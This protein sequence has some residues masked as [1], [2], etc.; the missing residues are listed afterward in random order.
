M[1]IGT[2]SPGEKLTVNGS[3]ML[4]GPSN[5]TDTQ[6]ESKIIFT[7]DLTDTDESE[8]NAMIYTDY[9]G[10]LTLDSGRGVVTALR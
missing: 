2:D 1:G 8:Y 5:A 7:R 3:I 4:K 9:S 6:S 10:P